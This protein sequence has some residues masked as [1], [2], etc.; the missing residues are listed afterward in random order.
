MPCSET[1]C[2]LAHKPTRDAENYMEEM[3]R[4]NNLRWHNVF[5]NRDWTVGKF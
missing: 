4:I 2:S 5:Q 1:A 3:D